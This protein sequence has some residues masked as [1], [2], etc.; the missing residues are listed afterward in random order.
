[1]YMAYTL[2]FIGQPRRDERWFRVGLDIHFVL[3]AVVAELFAAVGDIRNRHQNYMITLS[4][5]ACRLTLF[6]FMYT[7][8]AAPPPHR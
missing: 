6:V 2:A 8:Y 1:M 3:Y 7:R 5:A 4:V